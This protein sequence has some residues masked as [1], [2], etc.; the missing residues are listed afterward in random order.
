MRKPVL[1]VVPGSRAAKLRLLPNWTQSA[2][3]GDGPVKII[4]VIS[5]TGNASGFLDSEDMAHPEPPITCCRA[6]V[7]A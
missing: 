5:G 1:I 4:E 2:C 3:A 7:Q 6:D